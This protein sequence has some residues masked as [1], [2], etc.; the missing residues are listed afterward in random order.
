M[1]WYSDGM[2][3]KLIGFVIGVIFV[4][5]MV[6]FI[7]RGRKHG[8]VSLAERTKELNTQGVSN[9]YLLFSHQHVGLRA[10]SIWGLLNTAYLLYQ[11]DGELRVEFP[12]WN[13]MQPR[14]VLKQTDTIDVRQGSYFFASLRRIPK[15]T[16]NA[17]S[18]VVMGINVTDTATVKTKLWMW[19]ANPTEIARN[20]RQ[21]LAEISQ[22]D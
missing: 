9:V 13:T 1:F 17:F 6:V 5:P 15:V 18:F 7:S 22:R 11:K 12:W 14:F 2:E 20:Q 8:Y 10:G 19:Q 4:T 16:L 21:L 3:A